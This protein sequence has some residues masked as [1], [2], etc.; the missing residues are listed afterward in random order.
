MCYKKNISNIFLPAFLILFSSIFFGL[1]AKP[2]V[3]ASSYSGS[4]LDQDRVPVWQRWEHK[5]RST[6]TYPNPY[7]EV[8]LTVNFFGPKNNSFITYGFYNAGSIFKIRT[9]FPIAGKWTW[10]T[11]CSD[12]TNKGLH[13]KTG[14]INITPYHGRNLLYK[15]GFLKVSRNKRF[16]TY[17]DGT[18]FLWMGDTGW[19]AFWNST[20]DE[21]QQY[22]NDRAAKKFTVIQIHATK[23]G[24][25]EANRR[26]D[27]P[28]ENDLP[29]NA[30]W[31]DLDQ[32]IE[33]ANE[34][35]IV[36]L[37]VGLGFGGKGS[38]IPAMN[39][40]KFAQYLTGRL[41]G[42]FVI[43]SPSMDAPYDKRNDELGKYINEATSRHLITQHVGT[44]LKA[45]EEYRG[46]T[47]IDFTAL[48][49]GHHGG[50]VEDAYEA[51]R[52]WPLIL[53]KD[54]C[55]KPIIN[56]EGMYDGR[57]N[58]EGSNWRE[59]D[60]RKIGWLSWLSG[61]LGYTYG[62]GEIDKHV[63]GVMGGFGCLIPIVVFMIL[64]KYFELG[65]CT[66]NELYETVIWKSA[67]VEIAACK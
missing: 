55:V 17:G 63:N 11:T 9:A 31:E 22:I 44:N 54:E 8:V 45:A 30:Y 35:G 61:A 24:I 56:A 34:R 6:N 13:N 7:K 5:L 64:E 10:R 57:G 16:L 49:S 26:G 36:I 59:E 25:A 39:T 12:T 32:K 18:P 2:N 4:L 60:V 14:K 51:A 43:F 37:L 21:W 42:N 66:T 58:N 19:L 1:V 48:Q 38:Y 53:W 41:A 33:Y 40:S 28:F 67:M 50:K 3:A 27:L 15:N 46:K 62:V 29:N 20:R 23:F 47:Y 52:S 65:K